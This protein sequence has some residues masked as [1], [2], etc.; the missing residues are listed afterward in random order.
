MH[1]LEW[2]HLELSQ[3]IDQFIHSLFSFL[4]SAFFS[5]FFHLFIQATLS[6]FNNSQLNLL[7]FF[8][9]LVGRPW[10]KAWPSPVNNTSGWVQAECAEAF[11][12]SLATR[13][14]FVPVVYFAFPKEGETLYCEN[15]FNKLLIIYILM[16][17]RSYKQMEAS[18]LLLLRIN[19][20]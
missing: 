1:I 2:C 5:G 8:L 4:L 13:S 11:Y 10:P 16:P 18:L 15:I 17:T 12:F 14:A 9:K 20:E 7:M 6:T 3:P 19:S